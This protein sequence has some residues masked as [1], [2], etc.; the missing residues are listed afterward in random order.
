MAVPVPRSEEMRAALA[1]ACRAPSVHNT[2]PWHWRLAEHSVHLYLDSA[3]TLGTLDPTGREAVISCGAVL[4]HAR[5]AFGAEGWPTSVHRLPDPG[6]PTH[7]AA[8][9][10]GR[11]TEIDK[12]VVEFAAAAQHRRTDRRPFLPDPV[13]VEIMDGLVEAARGQRGTLQPITGDARR[14]LMLAIEHA[15]DQQRNS[16]E[17]REELAAWAG[18]HVAGPEGVPAKAVPEQHERGMPGRDF[19]LAGVGELPVPILDDG[20]TLAVLSTHGDSY[21]SWLAAGEALSAVVLGAEHEGLATC[22]LSQISEV[23]TSRR[24]VRDQVLDGVGVPQLVVR[25]GWPVTAEMPGTQTPRR[26]LTECVE[27]LDPVR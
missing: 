16:A 24:Y 3:R 21:E 8:I 7:L 4:H 15:G 6:S 14:E 26:P 25:V 23:G 11:P 22:P 13:A 2:Q 19:G 27:P 10:F 20:A 18:R 1:V 5:I 9:E 17:Y 12:R